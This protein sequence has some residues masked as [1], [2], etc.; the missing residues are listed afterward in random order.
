MG[1]A[2]A[3]GGM[4]TLHAL[5]AQGLR[6]APASAVIREQRPGLDLQGFDTCATGLGLEANLMAASRRADNPTLPA[7]G[8]LHLLRAGVSFW[9][10][11]SVRPIG[12]V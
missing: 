7:L 9:G 5:K 8:A 1:V 12:L 10:S 2:I 6:P 3:P 4:E 11:L